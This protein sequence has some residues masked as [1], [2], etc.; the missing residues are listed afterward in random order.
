M[1][2]IG[3]LTGKDVISDFSRSDG[4]VL[5]LDIAALKD[6]NALELVASDTDQGLLLKLLAQDTLTLQA[7]CSFD[8]A[9]RS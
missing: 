9:L 4:D 2:V 3:R 5:M 8:C 6:F 7:V 1:R